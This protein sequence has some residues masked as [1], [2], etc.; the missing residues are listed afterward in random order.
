M[1]KCFKER[2][3]ARGFA[4]KEGVDFNDVLSPIVKHIS[5]RILLVMVAKFDLE[6]EQMDVKTTFMYGDLD[7]TILM[8]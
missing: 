2:L 4:Q 7:E 1:S 6:L 8:R 3:V 5:I